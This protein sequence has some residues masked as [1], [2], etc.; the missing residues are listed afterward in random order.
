MVDRDKSYMKYE[1]TLETLKCDKSTVE[2][3]S[4]ASVATN[5]LRE[6]DDIV[7]IMDGYEGAQKRQ[8]R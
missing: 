8:S 5:R 1:V 7:Q 6:I 4:M 2:R 3:P